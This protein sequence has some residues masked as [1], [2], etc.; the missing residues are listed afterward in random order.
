[1]I[2]AYWLIVAFVCGMFSLAVMIRI[3]K[4]LTNE[5]D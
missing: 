5:K 2:E 1:M 4:E 3:V